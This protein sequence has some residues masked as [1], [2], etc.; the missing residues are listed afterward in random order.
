MIRF[1][2]N[3]ASDKDLIFDARTGELRLSKIDKV[4]NINDSS[5]DNHIT[6]FWLSKTDC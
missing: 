2:E 1:Q 5:Q 6:T 3:E 4:N